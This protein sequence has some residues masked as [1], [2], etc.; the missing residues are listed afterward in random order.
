MSGVASQI[1]SLRIVYSTV[2]PGADQ[3]KHQSPASLA[4]V[5]GIR[6]GPVNSP[7]KWSV[8][9]KWFPF[10]DVIM[11]HFIYHK[12]HRMPH[13]LLLERSGTFREKQHI[14]WHIVW[15]ISTGLYELLV[16]D[17]N[18]S[19]NKNIQTRTNAIRRK[20]SIQFT[21]LFAYSLTCI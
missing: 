4:F 18:N 15:N 3:R 17:I 5:W 6:R 10:D 1:T 11:C 20:H 9:R 19:Y 13:K 14:V 7:H 2:Y 16:Y 12:F 8:T 21:A